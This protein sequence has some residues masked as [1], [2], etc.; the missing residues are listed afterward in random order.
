MYVF[1]LLAALTVE[2]QG[3]NSVTKYIE[4]WVAVLVHR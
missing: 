2:G 4:D 3:I 1:N